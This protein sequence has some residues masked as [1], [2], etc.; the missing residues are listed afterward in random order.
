MEH[1]DT[2]PW[3]DLTAELDPRIFQGHV[4]HSGNVLSGNQ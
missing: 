1:V 3:S 4:W 2:T